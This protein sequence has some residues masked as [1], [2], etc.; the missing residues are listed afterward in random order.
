MRQYVYFSVTPC[1]N[2][3]T[4][5]RDKPRYLSSVLTVSFRPEFTDQA[6]AALGRFKDSDHYDFIVFQL[7]SFKELEVELEG[8]AED[9]ESVMMGLP[10]DGVRAPRYN[11]PS[12][13]KTNSR[14]AALFSTI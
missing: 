11:T 3:P 2:Y 14:S 1:H 8:N 10:D 7:T 5:H 13:P 9:W 12:L 4:L 6:K